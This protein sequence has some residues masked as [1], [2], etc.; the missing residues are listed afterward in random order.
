MLEY[1]RK[2][3]STADV[4]ALY[5]E[6]VTMKTEI[7]KLLRATDGYVSGQQISEQLGVSRAAVWKAIR[8]LQD[9][10]YQVEAVRNKGYHIVGTPDVMTKEEL[11]SLMKTRWAGRNILYYETTDSTNLRIRQAGDEGAPHGTLAVA[12]RQT[13]GRGRRG[14]TWESPAGS[15]IYMSVLLRPDIAPNKA[16]M[17]TL[18][19]ALSVAEGIQ[20]CIPIIQIKWPND[21]IVNGKKLVG[22]LTE[23]SAQVDYINHVTVGVG[24]NVN[25]TAFQEEIADTATSL[26]LECGHAVKRAPLI[27]AVMERLEEN[28]EIFLETE[29]LSGLMERYSALLVNRDRDVRII[30][31]KETYQAHAIG[32]DRT[33]ELIVRREDGTMEKIY[34]GEV[35]VR[36]VYG[37][38]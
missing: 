14:R 23:M 20:Q 7:L 17:L 31:E 5:M 32:I 6:W 22:I 37:Y 35:S 30:G 25:M 9:E 24:I 28:Y 15:S 3:I 33:G 26:R 10:G 4:L 34:A 16:S 38:V 18:V 13:A 19:M 29:D 2:I 27:A 8:R 11:N 21:I 1:I 36:G 12:D